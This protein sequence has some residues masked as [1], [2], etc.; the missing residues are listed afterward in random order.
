MLELTRPNNVFLTLA[1]TLYIAAIG[2]VMMERYALL[3][4]PDGV[5]GL[6]DFRKP[7]A[8]APFSP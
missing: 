4:Q 3:V 5:F 8:F 1:N 2:I 6:G 7:E